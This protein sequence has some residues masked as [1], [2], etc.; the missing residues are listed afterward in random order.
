MIRRSEARSHAHEFTRIE[1]VRRRIP[2]NPG[3]PGSRKIQTN[4]PNFEDDH[5]GRA[6]QEIRKG[7]LL[8]A[9]EGTRTPTPLPVHGPEPCASANSATMASGLQSSQQPKA[10]GSGRLLLHS[11]STN[12][13]V[14]RSDPICSGAGCC[15]EARLGVIP[16]PR[17]LTSGARNLKHQESSVCRTPSPRTTMHE[18]SHYPN[19]AFIEIFAF[20][21]FDTGHPFSAASAYF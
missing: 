15:R 3:R 16:Q 18:R 2:W 11:T 12:L 13:A 8:G 21:T 20:N 10:A 19:F 5:S 1:N 6:H 17:V 4:A 7:K 14:K 9:I